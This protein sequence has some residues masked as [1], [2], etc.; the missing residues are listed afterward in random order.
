MNVTTYMTPEGLRALIRD[1]KS[2]RTW[3]QQK[4]PGFDAASVPDADIDALI[5][6]LGYVSKR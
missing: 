6:F 4:M 1:P 3:P 2:V 5:S